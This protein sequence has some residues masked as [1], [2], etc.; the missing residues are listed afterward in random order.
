MRDSEITLASLRRQS[1]LKELDPLRKNVDTFGKQYSNRMDEEKGREGTLEILRKEYEKQ[2]EELSKI[3]TEI[4][5]FSEER[6][7]CSNQMLVLS[8]QERG[9]EQTIERLNDEMTD[10]ERKKNLTIN[11]LKSWK[12]SMRQWNRKLNR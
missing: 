2:R 9:A 6:Q 4:D 11:A 10:G 1:I 5:S 8:E 12:L 3:Q 7:V